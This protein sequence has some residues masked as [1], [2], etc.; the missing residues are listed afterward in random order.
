MNY[1]SLGG[2]APTDMFLTEFEGDVNVGD[3]LIIKPGMMLIEPGGPVMV[4][5]A[6]NV[7]GLYEIMYISSNYTINCG[8]IDIQEVF[9]ESG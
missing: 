1:G 8:R 2:P 6:D 5:E 4:L 7:Q 9:S 3:L